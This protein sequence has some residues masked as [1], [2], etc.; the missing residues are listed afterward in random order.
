MS[1]VKLLNEGHALCSN[2]RASALFFL[3][4]AGKTHRNTGAG[5]KFSTRR[6]ILAVDWNSPATPDLNA[7]NQLDARDQERTRL[8]KADMHGN[9]S[10]VIT[11]RDSR[12]VY[13]AWNTNQVAHYDR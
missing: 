11:R 7:T 10:S 6:G 1:D 9:H 13:G 2:R 5:G 12:K 3:A 4:R 8:F